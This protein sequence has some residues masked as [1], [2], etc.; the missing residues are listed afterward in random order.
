MRWVSAA[1]SAEA[2]KRTKYHELA[3]SGDYTFAPVAIE[4]LGVWG[5]SAINLCGE[6]GRRAARLTGDPRAL[7]FLKQ[8]FD[9]AVQRGNAAAV[10][11]TH[12]ERDCTIERMI[13]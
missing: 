7:S 5:A 12:P 10:T 9:L 13:D 8:R 11:G 6:N 1:A 2:L 4:T 3:S